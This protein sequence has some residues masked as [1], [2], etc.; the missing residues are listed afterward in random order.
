VA[1]EGESRR[2]TGNSEGLSDVKALKSKSGHNTYSVKCT[3]CTDCI[4]CTR[5]TACFECVCQIS[6]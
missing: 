5:I 3:L 6:Y 1:V 2:A 4:K